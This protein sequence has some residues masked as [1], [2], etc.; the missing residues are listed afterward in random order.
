MRNDVW[1]ALCVGTAIALMLAIVLGV[2]ADRSTTLNSSDPAPTALVLASLASP[3]VVPTLNSRLPA[4]KAEIRANEAVWK[5]TA[6]T[7]A[8]TA[9]P[10]LGDYLFDAPVLQTEEKQLA[11]SPG[12]LKAAREALLTLATGGEASFNLI[13]GKTA[14][15]GA[16][17]VIFNVSSTTESLIAPRL[18]IAVTWPMTP[19]LT[20]LSAV[21]PRFDG[22]AQAAA[23]PGKP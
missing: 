20:P 15:S 18:E 8:F 3:T 19:T 7:I 14:A 22:G 16:G 13:F 11:A 17:T 4:P 23:T 12:S 2:L 21:S 10:A 5:N 1:V 6:L 9:L